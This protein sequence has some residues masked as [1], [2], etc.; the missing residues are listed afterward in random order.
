MNAKKIFF[1]PI[2]ICI[3]ACS[4]G[5]KGY[6]KYSFRHQQGTADYDDYM[7]YDDEI[8]NQDS[9]VFNPQ[10]ASASISFAMASFASMDETNY[11]TKS[12]NAEKLLKKIGFNEFETNQWFKEKP[13]SDTIGVLAAKKKIGDYTVVAIGLRGAAYYSEWA[14]NFTLGNREDG[15]HDGFRTAA[16]NTI[17]YTKEYITKHNVSG[18]IKLWIAGYSRA[19]ATANLT[20]GLL[21]E[22]INKGQKPFGDGVNL[23]RNHLYAYCFEAPQ[24]APKTYD[25]EDHVVVKGSD[26]DNIFNILNINDPVP[27]VAMKEL[28]F[29]RYGIDLYLPDPLTNLDYEEHMKNM[30]SLYNK[31]SNHEV[32]GEYKIDQFIWKGISNAHAMS[33][34]LFLRE[35]ISDLTLNGISHGGTIALEN[36]LEFYATNIQ[37]GLRNLFKTLYLSDAFKGSLIDLG[38]AMVTDLGI[39]DEVDYLISDLVAEGPQAFIDDFRPI[40][41]RGLNSL[42]LGVDVKQ[43]VD[44]LIEFIKVIGYEMF[45][46]M[47]SGKCYEMLSWF[48]A[49]N[50]KCIASGHYPELCAAHV[51]ALDT[52]YVNNPYTNYEKMNGQYYFLTV[53]ADNGSINI[54]SN[55]KVVVN[56]NNGEEINNRI[57]YYKKGAEYRIYLPYN[58]PYKV[59]F[60]GNFEFDLAY[61]DSEYQEYFTVD[62]VLDM[63]NSFEL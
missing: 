37:E 5:G 21:D 34:G 2:I 54:K 42:N 60:G 12:K 20:A 55:D 50:L 15:Y 49:G 44:Q 10:L 26:F 14:S 52:S 19:G 3:C 27:L 45:S 53:K 61:Y 9:T 39:I 40:L 23:T 35:V 6:A 38:L 43:T 16:D 7:Y 8:F 17:N 51:R 63:S 36:C 59:Q 29:S 41:T 47:V 24:G 57:S 11:V 33:Q 28:G 4:S 56:I 18:D 1:L 31:V 22:Q 46:A 25:S 30:K 62:K 48:N 13:G 32:L 58:E